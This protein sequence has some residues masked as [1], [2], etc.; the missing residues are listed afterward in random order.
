MV[1]RQR[2]II[3]DAEIPELGEQRKFRGILGKAPAKRRSALDRG[4]DRAAEILVGRFVALQDPVFLDDLQRAQP[5]HPDAPDLRVQCPHVESCAEQR[6]TV[7]DKAPAQLIEHF[8]VIVD[9]RAFAQDPTP[10]LPPRYRCA[11][12]RIGA[13]GAKEF[14]A[15]QRGVGREI[16]RHARIHSRKT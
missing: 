3:G 12:A 16:Q 8:Y 13:F 10:D 4:A 9:V 1:E 2:E 6:Q 5:T 15:A 14:F 11:Q 7:A